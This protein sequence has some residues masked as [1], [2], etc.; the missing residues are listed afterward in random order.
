MDYIKYLKYENVIN[1]KYGLDPIQ[2]KVLNEIIFSLSQ[3][4]EISVGLVLALTE[5]AS[6]ATLHAALKKL[7]SNNMIS[8]RLINENR[9]KFIELT[10]LGE[11]RY[12]E[13]AN[14]YAK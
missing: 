6:R 4:K 3:Q 14:S 5:I 8:L 1:L 7:I 13:L 9:T 11:Q 10:H 12:R 2:I